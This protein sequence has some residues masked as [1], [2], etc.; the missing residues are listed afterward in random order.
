MWLCGDPTPV[1]MRRQ[2]ASINDVL[3]SES[4]RKILWNSAQ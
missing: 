1:L 4:D 2:I 3:I